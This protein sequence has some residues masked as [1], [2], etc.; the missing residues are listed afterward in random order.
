VLD[1]GPIGPK[2][3]LWDVNTGQYLS[4]FNCGELVL[5][6]ALEDEKMLALGFNDGTIDLWDPTEGKRL[7]ILDFPA[8]SVK[9]IVFSKDNQMLV[10]GS[11]DDEIR[12]VM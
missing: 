3:Q 12:F 5:S 7:H 11:D 1:T 8:R 9:A 2:V 10:S 6:I 4:T